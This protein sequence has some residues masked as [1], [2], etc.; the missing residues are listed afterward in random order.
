MGPLSQQQVIE[1]GLKPYDLIW[2]EGRSAAWRYANEIPELKEYAPAIE[3]QP[4]DRF[5]KK[6][7]AEVV[8]EEVVEP[9]RRYAE[10]PVRKFVETEIKKYDR[11]FEEQQEKV[12]EENVIENQIVDAEKK[13]SEIEEHLQKYAGI[14]SEKKE[15]VTIN[16]HYDRANLEEIVSEPDQRKAV[17]VIMPKQS[18]A[19]RKQEPVVKKV[20]VPIP[21]HNPEDDATTMETKYSTP[22]DEIKERY[23]RQLNQRKQSS[24]QRKFVVSTLKRAAIFIVII[25]AGVLIGFA[26]KPK[27]SVKLQTADSAL[28]NVVPATNNQVANDQPLVETEKNTNEAIQTPVTTDNAG[29]KVSITNEEK[30]AI[31][32]ETSRKATDDNLV[33]IPQPVDNAN[34]ER[35]KNVR[36]NSEEVTAVEKRPAVSSDL[37]DQVSVKANNYKE[38]DFGGFRNLQLTVTNDSKA[39]LESVTVELTYKKFNEDIVSIKNIPFKSIGPGDSLTIKIP[40]NSRG[41]KLSYRI[42]RIDPAN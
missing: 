36:N 40:D 5:Y 7:V 28:Q 38:R 25:G 20:S 41:A 8:K 11:Q 19:A 39:S 10:A 26:I 30:P 27:Q 35:N 23:V 12:M 2:I 24:A 17:S 4:Y 9:V 32:K 22:L 33:T 1:L 21:V 18:T 34:G 29:S 3:E 15:P 6:N 42:I 16:D 14:K 31:A 37:S 13:L